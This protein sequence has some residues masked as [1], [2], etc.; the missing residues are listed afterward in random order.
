MA[1]R[2]RASLK[3]KGP[4]PLGLT[5]KKG[6]GIDVLFGGPPD[7]E[8][9]SSTI[10]PEPEPVPD[11]AG[12][13]E[14]AAPAPEV[15]PASENVEVSDETRPGEEEMPIEAE[16][17]VPE[18]AAEETPV[19]PPP[20][21]PITPV[22]PEVDELG[23]P[24]AMEAP[25]DDLEFAVPA[26]EAGIPPEDDLSGL[27]AEETPPVQPETPAPPPVEIP[28]VGVAEPMPPPVSA[29]AGDVV[30]P[31]PT[32]TDDLAGLEPEISPPPAGPVYTPP[33]VSQPVTPAPP[34]TGTVPPAPV[35]YPPSTTTGAPSLSMPRS[36]IESLGGIITEQVESAAED[37]LPADVQEGVTASHVLAV[38][39][40]SQLEKDEVSAQKVARY[41]GRERR[42][43]LDEE[44]GRLY[45]EVAARL[46]DHKEDT[47]FALRTLS[48]AHDIVLEDVRQYDEALYRVAI[49]KAMLARKQNLRR[50]SYT[51]GLGVFFYALI[52]LGGFIAGFLLNDVLSAA[53]GETSQGLTTVRSAWFSALAGGVGG[54]IGIFYS[55]YWHV[56]MKQDFDRQYVMY[57]LVQP[58]MGFILGAVIYFIVVA[59]FLLFNVSGQTAETITAISVVLGFVAGF[60]QRV[61]FEMIDRIVKKLLPRS[62]EEPDAKPVSVIPAEERNFTPPMG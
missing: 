29:P 24:V 27:M 5:Q 3:D 57:Y 31:A 52:W 16:T 10:T 61:V 54:I 15:E 36:R 14:A 18:S 58:I 32:P 33:P 43:Q 4:D 30:P 53:L 9:N 38:K 41:V 48:E 49:V 1:R 8:A 26:G 59:G 23:L 21:P 25:P 39:E 6:K 40:R 20:A 13:E 11:A 55:L 17:A 28:P 19:A 46:S 35:A 47:E 12:P 44:I 2:K 60:R 50:W 22:E 56:A 37:L 34:P 42:E 62:K 51:Y 7:E 45:E